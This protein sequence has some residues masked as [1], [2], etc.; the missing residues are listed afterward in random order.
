MDITSLVS[1]I[2]SRLQLNDKHRKNRLE[3]LMV[4]KWLLFQCP[5]FP[6]KDLRE[7]IPNCTKEDCALEDVVWMY[8]RK[9]LAV[10]N[11]FIKVRKSPLMNQSVLSIVPSGSLMKTTRGLTVYCVEEQAK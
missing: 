9:N 8:A 4:Q 11:I 7:E 3:F 10:L 1:V 2:F 5:F 6:W